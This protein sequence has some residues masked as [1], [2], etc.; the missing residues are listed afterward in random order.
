MPKGYWIGHVEV[1][2]L[3][4]YKKYVAAATPAYKEYG[5]KFHVRGGAEDP[6]EADDL[7]SRHVVVEFES[8]EMAKACYNS[9]TY[10]NARKHRLGASTGRLVIVEGAE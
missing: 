10:Q 6:V 9:E 3:E 4:E 8:V 7:G 2:D 5:A 1:H